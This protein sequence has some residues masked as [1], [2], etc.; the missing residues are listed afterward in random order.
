[1]IVFV[2][3]AQIDMEASE[4]N[5]GKTCLHLAAESL[6]PSTATILQVL[7]K[8]KKQLQNARDKY[9][10][11]SLHSAA[12]AGNVEAV[13][14]L[15]TMG[16]D[17]TITDNDHYTAMHLATGNIYPFVHTVYLGCKSVHML[18]YGWYLQ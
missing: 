18:S 11:T 9:G 17:S 1:M 8:K 4:N 7:C 12:V 15:L 2:C 6:T 3:D 10:R 16:S 5:E 14:I 13:K